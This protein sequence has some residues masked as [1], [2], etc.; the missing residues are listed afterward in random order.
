MCLLKLKSTNPNFS[1]ILHK[2]PESGM[3]LRS[4]RQGTA[5]GFYPNKTD[6][7]LIFFKD[8]IN[9]MS[10]KEYSDQHYEYLNKLRYSSPIFVWNAISEFLTSSTNLKQDQDLNTIYTHKLVNSA[11]S[12]D[13]QTFKMMARLHHFFPNLQ[14]QIEE[15]ESG[16]KKYIKVYKIFIYE[17]NKKL[18]KDNVIV[19]SSYIGSCIFQ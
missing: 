7:Y 2:N 13:A 9:E 5:F 11:V 19:Y 16:T 3:Q 18:L 4:M 12:I 14:I 1:Y 15:K 10:Y 8:G 6:T 17:F